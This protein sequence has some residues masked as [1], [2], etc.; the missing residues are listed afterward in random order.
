MQEYS[1]AN[2]DGTREAVE[3]FEK[4]VN[5]N[6]E[7]YFDVFQIESIFDFYNE[8]DMFEKAE[9]AIKM[10]LRQ[11][12]DSTSLQLKYS[13][14]LIEQLNYDAAIEILNYIKDIE[15]NNSEIFLKLRNCLYKKA[16]SL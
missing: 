5:H 16:R 8:K 4:L 10:G 7:S 9:S 2:Q 15:T 14:L 6:K 11:H 13:S 1:H 12:P 3:R